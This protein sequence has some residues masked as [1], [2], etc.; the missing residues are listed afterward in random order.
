MLH[1]LLL[2]VNFL[3]ENK[4]YLKQMR[5][6]AHFIYLWNVCCKYRQI[7]WRHLEKITNLKDYVII[8]FSLYTWNRTWFLSYINIWWCTYILITLKFT[9]LFYSLLLINDNRNKTTSFFSWS[10]I[11]FSLFLIEW[12]YFTISQS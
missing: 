12:R 1:F 6:S 9:K 7:L 10:R 2:I 4:L 11:T 3:R 8:P 5:V